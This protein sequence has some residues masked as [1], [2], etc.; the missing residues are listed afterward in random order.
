MMQPLSTLPASDLFSRAMAYESNGPLSIKITTAV[1]A[2][3]RDG[4]LAAK[5]VQTQGKGTVSYES[6]GPLSI[7]ITPS[8]SRSPKSALRTRP[9]QCQPS[10]TQEMVNPV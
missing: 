1:K 6:N 3:G 2:G 9:P 4:V 10:G 5:A 8:L 7:K